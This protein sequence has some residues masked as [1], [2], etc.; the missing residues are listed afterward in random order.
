MLRMFEA[1]FLL[2]VELLVID[3]MQDHVHPAKIV[4]RTVQFLS[5]EFPDLLHLT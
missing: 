4:G 2:D 1:V 5:V 3:P